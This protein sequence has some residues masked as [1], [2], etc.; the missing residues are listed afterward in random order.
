[1]LH[2]VGAGAVGSYLAV[3][4]AKAEH[5][6]TVWDG[7]TVEQK[8]VHNQYF[9]NKY[10][11]KNKAEALHDMYKNIHPMPIFWTTDPDSL[12]Y[13]GMIDIGIHDAD[14]IIM[15]ADSMKVR[16]ELAT[17]FSNKMCFDVRL[18]DS[19][20]TI[21]ACTGEEMMSSL[22]YEDNDPD[23]VGKTPPC[24]MPSCRAD[25]VLVATAHQFR[26]IQHYIN[27]KK[28]AFSYSIGNIDEGFHYEE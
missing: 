23:I 4:L 26:N 17:E 10:I 11:G 9:T 8:N 12:A 2:Q 13:Q 14:F 18:I 25:L 3:A 22:N 1:M 20:Y 21:Y 15:S 27:H 6:I 19:V 5:S 16:R 7:D 28:P 24:H